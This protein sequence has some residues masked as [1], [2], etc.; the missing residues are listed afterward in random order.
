MKPCEK[1]AGGRER[2][3]TQHIRGGEKRPSSRRGQQLCSCLRSPSSVEA[4]KLSKQL[5][6]RDSKS[7][8]S[9][10]GGGKDIVQA[11]INFQV[12][13]GSHQPRCRLHR[14]NHAMGVSMGGEAL[15]IYKACVRLKQERHRPSKAR[16]RHHR[17][18]Q[19]GAAELKARSHS[20]HAGTSVQTQPERR[21]QSTQLRPLPPR[22]HDRGGGPPSRRRP[23]WAGGQRRENR[24]RSAAPLPP[25]WTARRH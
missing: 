1:G 25:T 6:R 5:E 8:G 21:G 17:A 19:G 12:A 16:L 22:A 13:K 18:T 15:R 14:V 23:P 10:C 7:K 9:P 20:T 11:R 2:E 3:T 24:S 4:S